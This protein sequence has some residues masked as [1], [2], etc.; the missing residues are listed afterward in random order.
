MIFI[1][2]IIKVGKNSNYNYIIITFRVW[3]GAI[4][5]WYYNISFSNF[6][7]L[8]GGA[9]RVVVAVLGA[10]GDDKLLGP[11]HGGF[12]A[13]SW[14][15]IVL[16]WNFYEKIWEVLSFFYFSQRKKAV[17]MIRLLQFWFFF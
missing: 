3:V 10:V 4:V 1:I 8:E 7:Y 2:I 17:L 15:H 11:D 5:L 9:F 13:K 12:E 16:A 6:E 14:L